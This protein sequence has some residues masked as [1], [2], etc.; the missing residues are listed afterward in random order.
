MGVTGLTNED[1]C[2]QPA[3]RLTI[4]ARYEEKDNQTVKL[5]LNREV[6]LLFE[7]EGI[8]LL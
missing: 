8:S 3:Y 4:A 7:R 6:K 1:V 2:E 5:F